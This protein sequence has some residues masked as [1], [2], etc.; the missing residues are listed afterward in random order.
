MRDRIME[1]R[2]VK[3]SELRGAPWNWRTHPE[4]QRAAVAGSIEEIGFFDPLDVRVLPDG[5]LQIIDGHL[6]QDIIHADV[7]PDTLVPVNVTDLTEEEA[8]KA[9]LT[10]DPLATLAESDA[11]RLDTLL[12]EVRI[13]STPLAAVLRRP[14][15]ASLA[16]PDET[17]PAPDETEKLV[18]RYQI[19]VTCRSE[20][21]QAELLERFTAEGLTCRSLIS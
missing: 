10:K 2:R 20:Q 5:T 6:R 7:G 4:R 21:E 1:L 3:A 18:E 19:L 11:G 8:K 14:S 12:G 16:H 13:L 9:N 15:G 17:G